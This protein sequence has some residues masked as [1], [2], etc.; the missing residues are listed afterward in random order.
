M[1]QPDAPLRDHTRGARALAIAASILAAAAAGM[2]FQIYGAADGVGVLDVLRST[3]IFLSTWWLAWGAATALLGLTSRQRPPVA[4]ITGPITGRTVVIVPVYN[5]DPRITFARIAAMDASII[6]THSGAQVD[7]AVLSD[8]RDDKI[9][10]QEQH[11]F[12]RLLARQHG[13]GRMFYRRR[14][15]NT[16][17]KAGNIEEFI[18]SSGAAWDYAVILDADSLM[19]GDTIIEMIRRIEA[20]PKLALLQ[21]L[22]RVVGG[23]SRFGRAMQFAA[24]FHSPIFARG[25]AATQGRTGPFWGHNAIVR[26]RAWA[27]SC[28]LPELPGRA[29][30]GGHIMSHDYVEAA[31]LA[32]AGWLVRLDDDLEGSYEEGPENIID[33]AKRDRRWCQGN[34]Q[35][36]KL[37]CAPGLKPWSRFVFVQGIFAYIAPLIWLAFIAASIAAVYWVEIPDYFP[38]ANWPFPVFPNDQTPKAIGLAVGVFGLLV[39]PKLLVALDAIFTGR[40]RGFGGIGGSLRAVLTELALS[41]VIAPILMAFQ[42]RSVLQVLLGRD[43]GWPPNNRGDGGL[44]IAEAWAAGRWISF[45]GLAGMIAIHLMAPVLTLWLM[46]VALPMMIAP[47]LIWWTSR[48]ASPHA[49]PVPEDTKIPPILARHDAVLAAWAISTPAPTA[50]MVAEAK[51]G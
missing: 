34:L 23:R 28:G 45:L 32:R 16:G 26:I 48:N 31:L 36:A 8:T 10:L 40:A 44:D 37:L 3:L 38:E 1:A 22:P 33:H 50:T 17:R 24:G 47:L 35:H 20:A 42:S 43:G 21:T 51:L 46:P 25:L 2:V 11:W 29:P 13:E 7:F 6:A 30:F 12:A 27:E 41:S 9:A 15:K 39:M 4:R 14:E 5:E 19:E 49:F 18:T